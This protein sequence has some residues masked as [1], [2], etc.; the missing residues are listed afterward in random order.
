MQFN[1]L[2]KRIAISVIG[3][4]VI[5]GI[6]MIGKIPFLILIDVILVMALW[7]LYGLAEKKGFSP[8]KFLGIASALTISWNLYFYRGQWLGE[9]LFLMFFL[10]LTTELFKGKDHSLANSA[11]TLF[12]IL[13]VSLF[14]SF[15]L[16]RE[17]PLRTGMPY[18]IGGWI[19]IFIFATIWICDTAAYFLGSRL[20]RHPL[21]KRVSPKKTWEGA[22]GGF[23]IGIGAAIG[24]RS[25]F[26]SSLSVVD[27]IVIGIIVGV[28]GQISDLVESLYKR[29]SGLKD[30]SNILPGHGGI[31][32]RFDSPLLVGPIV[33]FYL[34]ARGLM[35]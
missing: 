18:R 23:I 26:V 5:V 8:S 9:I 17:L 31:L 24:L 21:F 16:I 1:E 10:I 19:V 11:I 33:Y 30:S 2:G 12:G 14:S 20:G 22:I 32:D 13:Y 35:V 28:V 27:S 34:I 7:E 3:I 6:I 29:D 15:L 25:L 4:P